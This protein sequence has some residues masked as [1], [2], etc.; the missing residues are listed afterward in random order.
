MADTRAAFG[1]A[2]SWHCTSV[3]VTDPE[4]STCGAILHGFEGRS[5]KPLDV[6]TEA[7]G[8]AISLFHFL[9]RT[10]GDA[11]LLAMAK[12]AAQFLLRIQANEAAYPQLL[13]EA[14]APARLYAFDNAVCIVGMVRLQRA[15]GDER[16]LRSAIA[17][18]E[19]LLGMQRPDGSFS[20]MALRG[21]GMEDPGGFFGDGSCIHAKNAIAFLELHAMTGREQFR[22]AAARA[23]RYTLSLQDTDGAFCSRPDR[24]YIFT[25]AHCYA[26]EGLLYA[27]HALGEPAYTA[28]AGRGIQWLADAQGSDGAWLASHETAWSLRGT[29]ES[30]RRPRPSDAAAQA[31]R[32]FSLTAPRYE[33]NRLSALKFLMGCQKNNGAFAYQR[34][35]FGY[36]HELYTWCAQFAIQALAWDTG[37]AAIEDLF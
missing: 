18:G 21:G 11:P 12:V 25:H 15:T 8:Y 23:C 16:Y 17:A 37:R 29:L 30:I 5:G 19:W 32:L 9:A 14:A 6:Y 36:T 28:A 35:T 10:R 33:Q 13:N 4:S 7:T 1:K 34:T 31:A 24:R 27:G 3:C 20:A 22:E 2:L 26:C